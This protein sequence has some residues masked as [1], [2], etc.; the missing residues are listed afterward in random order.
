M[1][2]RWESAFCGS[3][4]RSSGRQILA[5]MQLVVL[6]A[7]AFRKHRPERF[8]YGATVSAHASVAWPGSARD[9]GRGMEGVVEVARVVVERVAVL[10][11]QALSNIDDIEPRPGRQFKSDLNR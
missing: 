10:A 5:P 8:E 7:G 9:T 3:T 4:A 1:N 2:V 11:P 6:V